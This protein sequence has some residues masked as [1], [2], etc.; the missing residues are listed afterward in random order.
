MDKLYDWTALGTLAGAAGLTYIV[1]AYTKR[2][3]DTIWPKILGT[4]LYATFVAFC[5]LLAAG[6]AQGQVHGW[7]G[8]V[9][10]AFNGFLVAAVAGKFHDT[11]ADNTINKLVEAESDTPDA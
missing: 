3:V 11:A 9:L 2:A 6:A 4:D 8:P 10:C 7:S 1:V 5:I